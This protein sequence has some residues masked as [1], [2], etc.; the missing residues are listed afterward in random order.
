MT[1][2]PPI[3]P[4]VADEAHYFT[5]DELRS[6]EPDITADRADDATVEAMREL[7]EEVIEHAAG[8]AF[9]PRRTVEELPVLTGGPA[10]LSRPLVREVEEVS[11][12]GEAWTPEEIADR[13]VV[14]HGWV[15]GLWA[16]RAVI[17][18]THGYD[19]PPGRIRRAAMIATRIWVLK[20]PI[21][22]RATQ[23]AVDGSTV[24]LATPGL[25]GFIT[26]IPE[27][28]AAIKGYQRDGFY[29]A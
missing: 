11:I 28:D 8:V 6:E 7:V 22:D 2:Y 27:V 5:V 24:N 9:L 1:T 4:P 23:L 3:D 16:R 26:G 10:R 20:G 12:D 17:T 13:L 18:Y 25:L 14:D 21:D 19:S 15:L 29:I